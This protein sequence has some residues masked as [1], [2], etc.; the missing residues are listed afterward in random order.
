MSEVK[1]TAR[2]LAH[3][4]GG[5]KG[6]APRPASLQ[7]PVR[8]P[9]EMLQQL[10]SGV[11]A[12]APRPYSCQ[13]CH[14]AASWHSGLPCLAPNLHTQDN[15]DQAGKREGKPRVTL[16]A[17]SAADATTGQI[18]G[19]EKPLRSVYAAGHV[20]RAVQAESSR[21]EGRGAPNRSFVILTSLMGR[22]PSEPH[23][24]AFSGSICVNRSGVSRR[25]AHGVASL[26]VF[27]VHEVEVL[28][29]AA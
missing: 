16:A 18:V 21:T 29:G 27:S 25:S 24:S 4:S 10:P 15:R 26:V 28:F 6:F 14:P 22:E 12:N 5:W 11:P 19:A 3:K 8:H 20:L 13:T 9:R 7:L 17:R 2:Q 1:C 23:C